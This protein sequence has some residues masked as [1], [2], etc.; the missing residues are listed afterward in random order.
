[1]NNRIIMT[2]GTSLLASACWNIDGITSYEK[3][4]NSDGK[5]DEHRLRSLEV[6]NREALWKKT[7][8]DLLTPGVFKDEIWHDMAPLRDLPA[9]MATLRLLVD[10]I[11]ADPDQNNK[12]KAGDELYLLHSDNNAGSNCAEVEKKL[13]RSLLPTGLHVRN[14]P[15]ANL[16][17]AD[18]SQLQVALKDV[19]EKCAAWLQPAEPMKV[20]LNLTG[21]YKATSMVISSVATRLAQP[22]T[23]V[24]GHES[25]DLA[26][27]GLY[28]IEIGQTAAAAV[29]VQTV[30]KVG[31][32]YN[33]VIHAIF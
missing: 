25:S 8:Q 27:E 12:L 28:T 15:I 1:M 20:W 24:Y 22:V 29:P 16:D 31:H 10:L 2:V 11:N 17:P 14:E 7:E 4:K 13:L 30:I 5:Y 19:M 26:R 18:K 3:A 6:K 32:V 21:G 33:G 9:E 23:I